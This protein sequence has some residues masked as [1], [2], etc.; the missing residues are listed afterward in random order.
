MLVRDQVMEP[1]R[2]G[3]GSQTGPNITRYPATSHDVTRHAGTVW[4]ARWQMWGPRPEEADRAG[5]ICM[6]RTLHHSARHELFV[7]ESV[8]A[9]CAHPF[10]VSPQRR[11][12]SPA[13][14]MPTPAQ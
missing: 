3:G 11:S 12:D 8:K 9:G 7:A 4:S 2:T 6:P 13:S 1:N 5:G 10:R 14:R